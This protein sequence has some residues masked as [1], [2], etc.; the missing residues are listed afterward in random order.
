MTNLLLTFVFACALA[1]PAPAQGRATKI[2][3]SKLPAPDKIVSDYLKAVG[4]KRRQQ[5][6]QD[7]TY[8]W[9][10]EGQAGA[11]AR[12]SVKA[13]ASARTD[14]LLA[15]GERNS[16]A[17]ARAAWARDKVGTLGTLTD[18]AANAAR[19]RAALS[20]GR[21][22]DYKRQD[23]LARTIAVEQFAAELSY[24]VEFSR[25]NGARVRYRFGAASKLLLEIAD[26]A[27]GETTRFS[28]YRAASNGAIEPHRVEIKTGEGAMLALVLR[29]ARYNTGLAD[30]LFEPPGDGALN[31]AE[32][33][34][35][36]G[37][38]QKE[39]DER[40]SQY[41]YTR[42]E[43]RREINDK[44]EVKKEKVSVYEVYPVAGAGAVEKLVSEDGASLSAERAA[45]EEKRVAEEITKLEAGRE[46]TK[47]KRERA[48]REAAKKGK[49]EE[50]DDPDLGTFLRV[51]EFVSPRRER[52]RERDAVVFD[53]R[54]RPG[55]KPKNR[56]E[57]V[58]SKL[59]GVVWIDPADKQIMR[60]EARLVEGYKV[61][62]GLVAS[63]R[64]GSAMVFEQTR[65]EDG[66]WLPKFQQINFA[67]KLFLFAGIRLDATR[68]YG[69]Y[70]RFS[71]RAGDEKLDAPK[72][73]APTPTPQ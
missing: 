36:V 15:G 18:T 44:G 12:T 24:V 19:L 64:P 31:V 22:V 51:C 48:R 57:S 5:L 2:A 38:N 11:R 69:N 13:P 6:I 10:V 3:A 42:R 68:E 73:P 66:V 16:A 41:T 53:F 70:K 55:Y 9:A 7:A 20:A 56:G 4:G 61:G 25:R 39:D 43:T 28:D 71:T 67:A 40:V 63:L 30:S 21:L 34:R 27:R 49:A 58:A 46:K 32:L 17:N 59:A 1:S 50:D 54:A 14:L 23:V 35:E 47:Q 60:L 65:L 8:E 29:E 33:L 37:R 26:D 72:P 62:G 52:F 45:K